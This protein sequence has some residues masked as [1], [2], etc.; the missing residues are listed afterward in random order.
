M[1]LLR[2]KLTV[3]FKFDSGVVISRGTKKMLTLKCDIVA[4]ASPYTSFSWSPDWTIVRPVFG[5]SS[6]TSFKPYVYDL[7]AMEIS[8]KPV[9]Q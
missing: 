6:K 3:Q 1:Y 2:Q 9:K 5:V 7:D 4:D 8:V